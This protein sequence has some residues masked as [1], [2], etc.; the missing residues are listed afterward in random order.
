MQ[1]SLILGAGGFRCA[2]PKPAHSRGPKGPR[3]PEGPHAT[4]GRPADVT[5]I[6]GNVR[7]GVAKR[8]LL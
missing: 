8:S 1:M 3:W 2:S 7:T 4:E 6:V 5:Y